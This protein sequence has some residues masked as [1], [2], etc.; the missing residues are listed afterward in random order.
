MAV[1]GE[2]VDDLFEVF[3]GA[4]VGV[5]DVAVLA[6]DAPAFDDLGRG[7]GEVSD[8]AQLAWSGADA[9][10][11]AERE[12]QRPRVEFG[13]VSDDDAFLFEALEAL[14]DCGRGQSDPSSE[15]GQADTSVG[16]EL[17]Q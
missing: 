11:C 4:H 10:H 7:L 17:G 9:N 13:V 6:G 8:P 2:S 16:L 14:S 3:D 5:H 15:L 1:D 12:A